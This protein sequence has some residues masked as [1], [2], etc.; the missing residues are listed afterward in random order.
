MGLE[1]QV[2]ASTVRSLRPGKK[3]FGTLSGPKIFCTY[4]PEPGDKSTKIV[5]IQVMRELLEG[6]PVLPSKLDAAFAYQDADTTGRRY[7]VDYVV[8]EKDPYYNGDDK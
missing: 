5:F 3:L 6:T 7:H 4:T 2:A 1:L 8:G